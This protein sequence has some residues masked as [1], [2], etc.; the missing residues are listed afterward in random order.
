MAYTHIEDQLV[1]AIDFIERLEST[2]TD[3]ESV[4]KIREFMLKNG[5]W[6]NSITHE[7]RRLNR[8]VS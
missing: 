8:E 4:E 1:K 2:C 7:D 6:E 5:Y 3:K